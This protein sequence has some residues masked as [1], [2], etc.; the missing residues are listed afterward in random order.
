VGFFSRLFGA[1]PASST[2]TAE[3]GDRLVLPTPGKPSEITPIPGKLV[4]RAYAHGIP[5]VEGAFVTLVTEGLRS[6]GQREI[7]LTLRARDRDSLEAQIRDASSFFALIHRLAGQGQIVGAGDFTQFGARGLLGGSNNGALYVD[8]SPIAGIDLPPSPLAMIILGP[9]EIA[10]VRTCGPYRVLARIGELYRTFPFPQWNDLQRPRV[11]DGDSEPSSL[12]PR[13]QRSRTPGVSVLAQSGHLR[14]LVAPNAKAILRKILSPCPSGPLAFLTDPAT[15]ANAWLLWKPG[16]AAPA[17]IAPPGA[18]GSRMTGHFLLVSGGVDRDEVRLLE[19]G[20][21]LLLTPKSLQSVWRAL[22]S[23][24]PLSLSDCEGM[25]F[26]VEWSSERYENAVDG[27][28]YVAAQG[29][30]EF[31]PFTQGAQE[32]E[33]VVLLSSEDDLREAVSSEQLGEYISA[34]FGELAA[35][36]H[37]GSARRTAYVQCTLDSTGAPSILTK[38]EPEGHLSADL[39]ARIARVPPP[40]VRRKI[41]FQLVIELGSDS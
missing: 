15:E 28:R 27:Q 6:Q 4:V 23:G 1:P 22:E 8:A 32:K 30:K 16:Q 14:M 39:V 25:T 5:N 20:Y 2:P 13:V 26:A 38:C 33:R 31:R 21:S 10:L 7:L 3:P 35:L 34:L 12:L 29:W 37:E 11:A 17:G 19:D 18:D 36:R 9:E 40:P 24:Q 41:A